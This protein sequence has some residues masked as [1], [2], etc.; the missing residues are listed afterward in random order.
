MA[1]SHSADE[2]A[3]AG[4]AREHQKAA[5]PRRPR[6]LW[7]RAGRLGQRERERIQHA[8]ARGVARK[9]RRDDAIDE[10]DAVGQPSVDRPKRLTTA[11]ADA[12]RPGRTSPPRAPPG[13]RATMSRIVPL[14][15]PAVGLRRRQRAGEHRGRHREDR[16]R[17]DR[18]ARRRRPRRSSAAKMA[19]RCHAGAVSPS[20][21]RHEPHH[22]G[23]RHDRRPADHDPSSRR[24]GR[25]GAAEPS[26]T[27]P[28]R[29]AARPWNAPSSCRTTYCQVSS[30][31]PA[32]PCV[33]AGAAG[34]R[35]RDPRRP[36]ASGSPLELAEDPIA[37]IVGPHRTHQTLTAAPSSKPIA[38]PRKPRLRPPPLVST[39]APERWTMR[40]GARALGG[41]R[42]PLSGGRPA[43]CEGAL[44]LRRRAEHCRWR[45]R[46]PRRRQHAEGD[47]ARGCDGHC[48]RP[49]PSW[50]PDRGPRRSAPR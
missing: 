1:V 14:A 23:E 50:P 11:V 28:L 38:S 42:L 47:G 21:R 18:E 15:N 8:G 7:P 48:G 33:A 6:S 16:G 44:S 32:M 22:E 46:R 2:S 27:R 12:L 20:G 30:Y 49:V 43:A 19:K 35:A 24:H 31:S 4:D 5:E 29:S 34:D 26:G 37:A 25:H 45:A 13:T 40:R 41:K 3:Q 17:E 39:I 9:R 10:E 36:V